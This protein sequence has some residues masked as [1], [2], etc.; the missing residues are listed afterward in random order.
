[1]K[2][3]E[4]CFLMV[5]IENLCSRCSQGC[6]ACWQLNVVVLGVT[7]MMLVLKAWR[8]PGELLRL[9]TVAGLGVPEGSLAEA[10]GER[11]ILLH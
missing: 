8:G 1:M 5:S 10:I 4:K 6:T 11:A 7:Q 9:G 2:S 3:F